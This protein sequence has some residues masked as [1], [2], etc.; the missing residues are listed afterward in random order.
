MNERIAYLLRYIPITVQFM[1]LSKVQPLNTEQEVEEGRTF[2][3]DS[4]DRTK[5][6]LPSRSNLA[7]TEATKQTSHTIL[8]V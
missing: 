4:A 8:N 7:A 1:M 5:L 6:Q 3:S 2:S